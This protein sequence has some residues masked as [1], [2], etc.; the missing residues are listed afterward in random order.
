MAGRKKFLFPLEKL[1]RWTANI[2]FNSGLATKAEKLVDVDS[3]II[4]A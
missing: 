3:T 4:H 2:N 1:I